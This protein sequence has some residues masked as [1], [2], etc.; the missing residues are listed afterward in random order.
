MVLKDEQDILLNFIRIN[1][2]EVR[3][4]KVLPAELVY[5][6]S[7]PEKE[8][9]SPVHGVRKYGPYDASTSDQTVT[10]KFD[11]MEFHVFYPK[12][13]TTIFER[14]SKLVSYL[15]DG[16]FERRG[17]D[18]EFKGLKEEFRL[19]DTIIPEPKEFREYEPGRLGEI[20]KSIDYEEAIQ[21]KYIPVAIIG[22]T[23]HRSV[24]VNREL[25]LEA[26]K[27]FTKRNIACQ[28]A[29]FYE[30]ETGS[31][32]ILCRVTDLKTPFGY[33][34]WNFALNVYGKGGG[35]AWVVRQKLSETSEEAIDL[36]I[37][38]RFVRTPMRQEKT[39]KDKFHI[40]Y[41]T[42]LDRFGRLIGTVSSKPF[43]ISV[44]KLRASGMVI[45]HEV[46]EDIIN[47]ALEKAISDSRF[48]RIFEVKS[49]IN[50]AIHRLSIFDTEEIQAITSG[51]GSQMEDK[52]TKF[53]LISVLGAQSVL[54]FNNLSEIMNIKKDT[55]ASLNENTALMYTTEAKAQMT[56]P[57][58]IRVQNLGKKECA[59]SSLTEACNHVVALN[60]LHWQTVIPGAVRLPASLEFAQDIA[61]LSSLNILPEKNSWLWKTL[62]FI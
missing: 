23:S 39:S 28:Y 43:Q 21:R 42:I 8:W 62:W 26:K 59:F 57:I 45:P 16:Y 6:D 51:I 49:T 17:V 10:R 15:N 20:A 9:L 22:G 47:E 25:Y 38:L 40:G 32:G 56:Y 31:L 58:T 33:S 29:S 61:H 2:S 50:I 18:T 3:E 5:S 48:K 7:Q 36:T 24:K 11:G 55:T 34:L 46:M 13:Q 52:T 14:L 4:I 54:L 27:E 35:I 60:A 44:D 1:K 19:K 12:G 53:S 41:A 30:Y 37:G